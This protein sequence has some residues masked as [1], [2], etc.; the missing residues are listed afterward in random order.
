M[1]STEENSPKEKWA[2]GNDD[3]Q[4]WLVDRQTKNQW[5]L[6]NRIDQVNFWFNTVQYKQDNSGWNKPFGLS[7]L[8]EKAIKY[9]KRSTPEKTWNWRL[10]EAEGEFYVNWWFY[11]RKFIE[12]HPLLYQLVQALAND[13]DSNLIVI[14][15]K[16][17]E[18]N[19]ETSNSEQ[20]PLEQ[21]PLE[22]SLRLEESLQALW[23]KMKKKKFI[24]PTLNKWANI[25]TKPDFGAIKVGDLSVA[26]ALDMVLAR[27]AEW[28]V[29][30]AADRQMFGDEDTFNPGIPRMKMNVKGEKEIH[31]P[32]PEESTNAVESRDASVVYIINEGK[33][34]LSETGNSSTFWVQINQKYAWLLSG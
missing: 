21:A 12:D 5:T 28:L 7:N 23:A 17:G 9:I 32:K 13:T 19:T 15:K 20:V 27:F 26:A 24:Y 6:Q 2:N 22:E 30:L 1:T 33:K 16:V 31:F 3:V 10:D 29:K 18:Q 11:M 4:K 8:P 14:L 34:I 25:F